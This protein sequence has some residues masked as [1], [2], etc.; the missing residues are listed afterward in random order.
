MVFQFH[1][2]LEGS[3]PRVWRRFLVGAD[4]TAADLMYS[5]LT[6][7]AMTGFHL[8]HL[9]RYVPGQRFGWARRIQTRSQMKD[10]ESGGMMWDNPVEADSLPLDMLAGKV[11]DQLRFYYDYG[12]DWVVRL[13]LE[14]ILDDDAHEGRLPVVVKGKGY[15]IVEDCGG[16]WVLNR[17]MEKEKL[18]GKTDNLLAFDKEAINQAL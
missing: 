1:A 9:E 5:L 2:L 14:A 12:D 3:Q 6:M 17:M 15:G 8:Y 10:M 18:A 11:G 13:K 4:S 16:V 7:F